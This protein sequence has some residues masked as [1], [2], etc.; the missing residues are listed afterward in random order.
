MT[1]PCLDL[2]DG[3]SLP[4]LGL[5]VYKI[6]GQ[7][8]MDHSVS[9][10][11]EAGYR[12]FDTAQMY[13]NEALLGN[14]LSSCGIDRG[15]YFLTGK[16]E[17]SNSVD[18][19]TA[20][21]KSLDALKTDYLDLFLIHWPGQQQERLIWVWQQLEELHGQG[22]IRSL[23]LSN[24]TEKHLHWIMDACRIAPAV[25]QVEH[26]PLLHETD[27]YSLCREYDIR[28]QAWAPLMR[29][30]LDNPAIAEIARRYG[31][32]SAQV[33]LRWNIQ[34]G[35]SAVPKSVH[36]ER[37]FENAS[38]F[39]FRLSRD[40]MAALDGMHIGKRTGKDPYSYDY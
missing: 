36:R 39:D 20:F 10:A 19:V 21:K 25:H 15:S 14:S 3:R 37:I 4:M 38:I 9:W 23:G 11:L 30:N 16:L 5:G 40:D 1:I 12:L 28:L 2:R 29:G 17:P 26:S 32:T 35:F 18:P 24:C 6:T 33:I 22:L 27:L 34:H 13:G 31:K 8:L 7:C